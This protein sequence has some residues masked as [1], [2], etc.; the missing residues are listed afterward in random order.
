MIENMVSEFT[1]GKTEDNILGIGKTESNMEKVL[2]N[3]PKA[4]RGKVSGKMEKESDGMNDD[5]H[6]LELYCIKDGHACA[7]KK[8]IYLQ[9]VNY[10]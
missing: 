3:K 2:T 1:L 9:F 7:Y 6:S 10:S 8:L 5:R 4:K